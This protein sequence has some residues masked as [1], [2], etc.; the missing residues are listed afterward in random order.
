MKMF[1]KAGLHILYLTAITLLIL[2]FKWAGQE[3]T[4]LP[5]L[6]IPESDSLVEIIHDNTDLIIISFIGSIP[7]FY[8]SLLYLTPTL[9]FKRSYTRFA[10]YV[11]S[12]AAYY[13]A[14]I[15]IIG[16]IFPMYYFFGTPY[17]IKILIPV[18]LISGIGGTVFA[19]ADKYYEKDL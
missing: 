9:L 6:P 7:I 12:L 17:A 11:A 2:Y 3:T 19:F 16:F 1:K 10:L 14:V 4:T 18:I 8:L 5:G 15:L 13:F